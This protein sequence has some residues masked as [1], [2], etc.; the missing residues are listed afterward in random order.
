[1]RG[2]ER[3][4]GLPNTIEFRALLDGKTGRSGRVKEEER[5]VEEE[6]GRG[7]EEEGREEVKYGKELDDVEM[8]DDS[9][10]VVTIA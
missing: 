9:G 3:F 5:G 7:E 4:S 8:E 6:E 10:R 1:M 2:A